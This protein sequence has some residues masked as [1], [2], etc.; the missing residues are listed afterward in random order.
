MEDKSPVEEGAKE[1]S[2]CIADTES[3]E[4][5]PQF[6]RLEEES[7][8]SDILEE[9]IDDEDYSSDYPETSAVSGDKEDRS[10]IG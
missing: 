6:V 2:S 1:S 5:E 3:E 10:P 4:S 9:E 7:A 8:D